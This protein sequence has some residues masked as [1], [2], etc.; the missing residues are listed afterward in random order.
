MNKIEH[1]KKVLNKKIDFQTRNEH[2]EEEIEIKI[3]FFDLKK[4][5]LHNVRKEKKKM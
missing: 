4:S 3:A 2:I 5:V 1:Y